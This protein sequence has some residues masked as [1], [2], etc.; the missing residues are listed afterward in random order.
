ML[1]CEKNTPAIE[2]EVLTAARKCFKGYPIEDNRIFTMFEH[3]QWWVRFFD[4][5]KERDRTYSVCD[6]EGIGTF[7]G[8]DFEEV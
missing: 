3:G 6:A 5:Q 4:K 1:K 8:F 7:D 2:K